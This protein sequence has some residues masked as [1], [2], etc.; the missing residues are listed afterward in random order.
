MLAAVKSATLAGIEGV[1]V[2]VE[3]HVSNGLPGFT[4]VGLPDAACRESRDRVR[5]ALLSTALEWPVKRVTV[6]LPPSGVR[7]SGSSLDLA[8]A[9]ALL[10]ASEQLPA[11][12]V[13]DRSFIG[14]TGLDGSLRSCAMVF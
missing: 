1:P 13:H 4:I 12:L 5:A 11:E 7:K 6:N 8:I 10:V 2:N 14:E 9:L 3:V